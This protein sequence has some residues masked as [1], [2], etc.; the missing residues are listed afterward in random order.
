MHPAPLDGCEEQRHD[1]VYAGSLLPSTTFSAD[2]DWKNS[3]QMMLTTLA[4]PTIIE[5]TARREG[6]AAD[7]P[8][9]PRPP[10]HD[11]SPTSK[12]GGEV[13]TPNP[14]GLTPMRI[15]IWLKYFLQK[16]SLLC[17]IDTLL[18][19]CFHQPFINYRKSCCVRIGTQCYI[20]F[21]HCISCGSD[22]P[23]VTDNYSL[24]LTLFGHVSL[25][26][27]LIR[28]SVLFHTS[29]YK[30]GRLWSCWQVCFEGSCHQ[31]SH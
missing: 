29:L 25:N 16:S 6:V 1:S 14:P 23:W 13:T 8:R 5:A 27:L 11:P 2:E 7:T 3:A 28:L 17:F 22:L 9:P 15:S 31:F 4:T 26:A 12:S 18:Q 19:D 21:S 20:K 10:P 30:R 24:V